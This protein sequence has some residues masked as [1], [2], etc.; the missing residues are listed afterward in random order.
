MEDDEKIT[1]DVGHDQPV[2]SPVCMFCQ[3]LGSASARTCAA[4][5]DGIPAVIWRGDND[6]TKPFPGDDGLRFKAVG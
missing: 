3:R 1:I 4:F 2:V 5:P 6:H